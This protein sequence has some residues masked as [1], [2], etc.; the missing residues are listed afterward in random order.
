M[1][2]CDECNYC[3]DCELNDEIVW[4]EKEVERLKSIILNA[5]DSMRSYKE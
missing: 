4:L 2:Q 5:V 1:C 3:P